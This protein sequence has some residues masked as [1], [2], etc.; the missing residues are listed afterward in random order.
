MKTK[1]NIPAGECH[2]FNCEDWGDHFETLDSFEK[3]SKLVTI[4]PFSYILGMK[5][6]TSLCLSLGFTANSQDDKSKLI[7]RAVHEAGSAGNKL[8]YVDR[9]RSS[10]DWYSKA[11]LALPGEGGF[12]LALVGF[13]S[14]TTDIIKEEFTDWVFKNVTK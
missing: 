11:L 10:M 3:D 1:L 6:F 12:G 7:A 13:N 2:I 5:Q 4:S 9:L 8:V 14:S